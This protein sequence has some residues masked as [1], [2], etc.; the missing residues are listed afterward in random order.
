MVGGGGGGG[1]GQGQ[2]SEASQHMGRVKLENSHWIVIH[3]LLNCTFST[4]ELHA[5]CVVMYILSTQV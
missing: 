4:P 3:L 2:H 1:G 5:A